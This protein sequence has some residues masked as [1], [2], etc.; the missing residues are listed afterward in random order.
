MDKKALWDKFIRTGKVSD[1]LH[2][3][4]AERFM[5]I[6]DLSDYEIAREIH[7]DCPN[8]EDYKYDNQNGRY[9]DS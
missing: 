1:Y 3:S 5:Q 8:G 6:E 9:S 4:K 2:Y 7:P